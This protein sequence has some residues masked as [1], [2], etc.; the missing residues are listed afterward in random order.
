MQHAPPQNNGYHGRNKSMFINIYNII[1]I[2]LHITIIFVYL[3]ILYKYTEFVDANIAAPADQYNAYID[4]ANPVDIALSVPVNDNEFQNDKVK[5][6]NL[7]KETIEW[8]DNTNA[9]REEY[10]AKKKELEDIWKPIITKVY[11]QQQQQQQQQQPASNQNDFSDQ[12]AK[13]SEPRIDEVA[14]LF[15]DYFESTILL[16]LCLISFV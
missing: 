6:N 9:E 14:C 16:F 5:L 3:C 12:N 11:G 10:D 1:F 15:F 7:C 13:H 4:P 2:S 8:I